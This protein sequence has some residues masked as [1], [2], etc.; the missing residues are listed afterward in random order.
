MLVRLRRAMV[1]LALVLALPLVQAEEL[2]PLTLAE[3]NALALANAADVAAAAAD[4]HSAERGL[5]RA[6]RDPLATG[7]ERMQARHA[8]DAAV[9]ALA[10]A[11]R[12]LA[13]NTLQRFTDVLEGEATVRD[14]RDQADVAARQLAAERVRAEAG[15][16]TALDLSRSEADAERAERGAREAVSAQALRWSELALHLGVPVDDVRA[17][18]VAPIDE[19]PPALETLEALAE[20]AGLHAPVGAAKHAAVAG[21]ERALEVARVQLAGSDH[22]AA[23]PNAVAA[24]RDALATAERRLA[25]AR[26]NAEL[27]LRSIHQAY[28][29][30]IGRLADTVSADANAV[31][32]LEAQR[33][34]AQAGELAPLVL[35]QAEME[36]ARSADALRAARHAAWLA[37]WRL[38]QAVAGQ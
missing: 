2:A 13:V 22:E 37:W 26:A 19:T 4:L 28:G 35:R 8:R 36:R 24:A 9:A 33:V 1:V 12:S 6:E 34:R 23:S 14:A 17:R 21:A 3:A 7:M 27:Q 10:A 16:I 32:T 11:E 30:A 25:D 15:L 5:D 38:E 29:A 20:R 18:G 31:T